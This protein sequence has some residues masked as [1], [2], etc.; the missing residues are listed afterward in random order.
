MDNGATDTAT[1]SVTVV[2]NIAPTAA[3][4][5]TPTTGFL[6]TGI[7][8]FSFTSTG[9]TDSDGTI[10]AYDWDFGDGSAHA[11][12]ASASHVYSLAGTHTVTLTVTDDN[13]A[14]D[15]ETLTVT[16]ADNVAPSA[17][18]TVTATSGTTAT[19][20]G[21]SAN[22]ADSDGTVTAHFWPSATAPL[23]PRR[24]RRRSTTPPVPTAPP[25]L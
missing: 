17:A 7:T 20:F 8:N 24:T 25:S 23:P 12:T 21:F 6:K 14:T 10:A 22:S 19:N 5:V 3:A 13:G 11:T 18:P 15:T 4:Q 1:L 16:V 2:D 9:S